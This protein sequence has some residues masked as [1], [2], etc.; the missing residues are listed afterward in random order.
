MPW[1]SS[2]EVEVNA[3]S[4]DLLPRGGSISPAHTAGDGFPMIRIALRASRGSLPLPSVPSGTELGLSWRGALGAGYSLC[5]WPGRG[6]GR[7]AL[8]SSVAVA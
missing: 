8:G 3:S 6:W 5:L 7:G 2:Q 1:G 4:E